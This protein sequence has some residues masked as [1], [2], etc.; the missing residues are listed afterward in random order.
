MA[1][2]YT[3]PGVNVEELYSPSVSPLLSVSAS[4]CLVGL[5]RGYEVGVTTA[6]F[7][8]TGTNEVQTVTISGT[9]TGGTFT[10][11]YS[12]QT[13]A[14]IAYNANAAAVTTALEALSNI[15]TG[16]VN[17]TG[18][19][20]PGVPYTVTFQGGLAGTNVAELTA[21][22]AGLT[23]GATPSVDISTTTSGVS[24]S[25][26]L[27]APIGTTFQLVSGSQ[28]F[29]SATNILDPTAG[30]A[31][32]GSYVQGTDF[33]VNLS[34]D[35]KAVTV[36]PVAAS[37]LDTDGGTV[38][39]AYR[40]VPDGYYDPIR[41][42]S[43][44][45][46]EARFGPAFNS[47]G[48]VT[49]LSAGAAVAFENGAATVV[50]L[51]LAVTG[52][53]Q[54]NA[55]QAADENT[56]DNTLLKLRDI[57]DVNVVVPIVGQSD[58]NVDDDAIRRIHFKFQDFARYMQQ[59]EGQY[60]VSIFGEDSSASTN[61]A[62]LATLRDHAN[63]LRSRYNSDLAEQTVLVSPSRF[64]RILPSNNNQSVLVGGQYVAAAIAGM[65]AARAVQQPLTRKQI[66]GFSSVAFPSYDKASKNADAQ[67][68]L[69][70]VEQKGTVV[71]VRH[72]VTL[73]NTDTAKRE[74][75][76]VRAKHRMIQSVR[77]TL[78]NQV[79]GTVPA[80]G[81]APL[82]VQTTVISVLEQ[83]RSARELVSYSA[84][85]ARTLTNDPTTV[86][87]RF[88]YKPAFPL[89]YVNVVFS[90]DL[91][92]GVNDVTTTTLVTV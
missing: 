74:L 16:D 47:S 6:T 85:E 55:T 38:Q 20:G 23:G 57:E 7:P 63:Q 32:D 79:I 81:N 5:A 70:V 89:N 31:A 92:T 73:N 37:G 56:W 91:S 14:A 21:N 1:L 66:S 35:S 64:T 68:G 76:V 43:Q 10:L 46:V 34:S 50:I 62:T 51:P 65:L 26:V 71:Q 41:L 28:V 49:P 69:L 54:P 42:D 8:V 30:S 82:L 24:K 17:V 13:T 61:V 90:L 29:D 36:V 22:D 84:V 72:G 60:V 11:T 88:S 9:P 44:S 2:A 48:I 80:D 58:A 86:E 33:Q 53:I 3:P 67:Q 87:V 75:S 52:D 15:G 59:S 40:F 83:L 27:N 78:D 4:V 39:F 45:A 25:Q 19:P 12:G 77:S 18:G